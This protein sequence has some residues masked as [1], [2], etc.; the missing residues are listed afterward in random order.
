MW[1]S[2]CLIII[3][4]HAT[5][6]KEI[7]KI[8]NLNHLFYG[9]IRIIAERYTH[10]DN[11]EYYKKRNSRL[12]RRSCYRHIAELDWYKSEFGV[13]FHWRRFYYKIPKRTMK[14]SPHE[15]YWYKWLNIRFWWKT[16][17]FFNDGSIMSYMCELTSKYM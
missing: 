12:I 16:S 3:H 8:Q 13:W 7:L 2:F 10:W 4:V 1:S 9:C 15:L 11:Y 14:C 5:L 17:G 6:G